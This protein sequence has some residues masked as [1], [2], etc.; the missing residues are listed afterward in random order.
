M[1]YRFYLIC[2]IFSLIACSP[3]SDGSNPARQTTVLAAPTGLASIAGDRKVFLVWNPSGAATSYQVKRAVSPGGVYTTIAK[4][5]RLGYTDTSVANGKTYYYV[6]SVSNT[7][8]ESANSDEIS[9]MPCIGMPALPADNPTANYIGLNTWFLNDYDSSFAFVDVI[10]H[11][12]KWQ[13]ADNWNI[14]VGGIDTLGWPTADASTVII[15][16]KPAQFNGKYKLVFNGRAD[17]TPM[18]AP[19]S[20]VTK[21]IYNAKTNTSTAD[22]TYNEK[23]TNRI[24]VGLIFKRTQRTANS[25]INTGFNNVHLYRPGYPSD[26]SVV[27]TSPFLN[28]MRKAAAVRMMDWTATNSN[29]LKHWSQR[30]TPAAMRIP[31]PAYAGPGGLAIAISDLGVAIEHEIQLCNALHSDCWINIPVA[32]D[33]DYVRKLALALRYGTD[34]AHPYTQA[35]MKPVYPPLNSNLRIYLEYAN[36]IW[37]SAEEFDS[38]KVVQDIVKSLP[39][40][41]PLFYPVESERNL[42]RMM[43]RYP[44]YR[45]AS[46][47]DIFRQVYGDASMMNRVRPML[48][49]KQG[50]ANNTLSQP[51]QWLDAYAHRQA[52]VREVSSYLYGAGG[53]AYYG[54]NA[55]VANKGDAKAFFVS[56]NYPDRAFVKNTAIDAVW[57]ANYGLKRIAYEGGLSLDGYNPTQADAIT[58]A[59][60][61]QT[62]EV[63]NH[64]AWSQNGGDLLVY[65]TLIGP[66]NWQFT[67]DITN[68]ATPKLSGIDQLNKQAR[69]VLTLGQPLPGTII[70]TDWADFTLHTGNIRTTRCDALSC[71]GRIEAGQWIALPARATAA[72]KA[73]L[74]VNAVSLSAA[75]VDVWVNGV[76][77]GQVS[78]AGSNML[79]NSTPL[80]I[81]IPLG[82]S[83]IRL[84]AVSGRFDLRSI[85]VD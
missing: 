69:A 51:L 77:K 32:A 38:F 58:R 26:G 47:S 49:T 61:M 13:D 7:V 50:N 3:K 67:S 12:R 74:M 28:A 37:N 8:G 46:I 16:A 82:L 52:P 79:A 76:N 2:L 30:I 10:K 4:T 45:M 24:S 65:Y 34:G 33:D 15:T 19:G 11:A 25:P 22:V 14:P 59:P 1:K 43:W 17:V 71:I 57:S 27:F 29:L 48:M 60:E 73:S 62:L 54:V 35:Q 5:T 42:Y 40:D 31:G 78:F 85:L 36:E 23:G 20:S 64:Q 9:S 56:G 83:V 70:A 81:E 80:S 39:S 55:S 21:P 68:T 6:L 41:H 18:W 53:S 72:F 44:A 75:I 84:E 66:E 63:A